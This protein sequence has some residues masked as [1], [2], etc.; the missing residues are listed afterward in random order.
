V[1]ER[2]PRERRAARHLGAGKAR[3]HARLARCSAVHVARATLT[4]QGT[5]AKPEATDLA[6]ARVAVL[7][8]SARRRAA[9]KAKPIGPASGRRRRASAG[10]CKSGGEAEA[11]S[12]GPK[13]E[14]MHGKRSLPERARASSPC[15][16]TAG[17]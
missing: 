16:A 7:V 4:R 11:D 12:N 15:R 8:V 9:I 13:L 1:A 10:E 17:S 3:S 6:R 2:E 14:W 5:L